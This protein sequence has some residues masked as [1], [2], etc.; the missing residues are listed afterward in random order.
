MVT[1]SVVVA[2]VCVT[3]DMI[4]FNPVAA[5]RSLRR[6]TEGLGLTA[7]LGSLQCVPKV[8]FYVTTG[9]FG[10]THGCVD[11]IMDDLSK[12]PAETCSVFIICCSAAVSVSPQL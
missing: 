11:D 8:E 4:Q 5:D 3:A 12:Y 1:A 9:W 7:A 6:Q 2:V 10:L